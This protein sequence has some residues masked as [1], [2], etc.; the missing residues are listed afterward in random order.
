MTTARKAAAVQSIQSLGR[1]VAQPAIKPT[2]S[3]LSAPLESLLSYVEDLRRNN[4]E[5]ACA[6][7]VTLKGVNMIDLVY[8]DRLI[9]KLCQLNQFITRQLIRKHLELALGEPTEETIDYALMELENEGLIGPGVDS[10]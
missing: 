3:E 7:L 10:I 5:L 2:G 6:A 9:S 1:D 8:D 4:Y